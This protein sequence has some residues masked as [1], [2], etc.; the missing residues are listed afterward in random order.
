MTVFGVEDKGLRRLTE[1][2]LGPWAEA[3]ACSRDGHILL[4][5]SVRDRLIDLFPWDG[6]PLTPGKALDVKGAGPE[7]F[8]TP[9]P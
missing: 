8:A 2:P 4:V 5:R 6:Q 3:A 9:W 7:S 1:A